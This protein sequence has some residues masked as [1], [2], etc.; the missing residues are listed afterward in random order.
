LFSGDP[1]DDLPMISV[2]LPAHDEEASI[3][4]AVASVHAAARA[5]GEPYEVLVVDDASSDRTGERARAAGAQVLRVEHRQISR[6]RNAGARAARGDRFVFVDADTVVNAPVF[7]AAARA[8][9]RGAAGGARVRFDGRLPW[10]AGMIHAALD[11]A[12]RGGRLAAGCFLFCPRERFEKTG[13]FDESLYAGEEL[14]FSHAL[15]REGAFVVLSEC[16][17]TSGRKLRTHSPIETVRQVGRVAAGGVASLRRRDGL[18][19]WYGS[20]REDEESGKSA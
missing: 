4:L 12:M 5:L 6:T 16:V 10:Y 3:A 7:R 19:M 9:A 2:I 17:L 14:A 8:L 13:G 18:E 20:R 1:A 15:K 11:L